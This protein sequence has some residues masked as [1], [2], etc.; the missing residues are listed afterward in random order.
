MYRPQADAYRFARDEVAARDARRSSS[1]KVIQSGEVM[2][3]TASSS[4]ARI[5]DFVFM[6]PGAN[7]LPAA[8]AEP[9]QTHNPYLIAARVSFCCLAEPPLPHRQARLRRQIERLLAE[10]NDEPRY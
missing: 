10:L 7:R 6:T 4:S 5:D 2:N 3:A 8:R 9:R 1:E